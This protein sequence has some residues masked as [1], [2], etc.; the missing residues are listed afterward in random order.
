MKNQDATAE[1]VAHLGGEP[2]TQPA[3]ITLGETV[4]EM[5][6]LDRKQEREAIELYSQIIRVAEQDG[7]KATGSLF[8]R[9][10]A[11]EEKHY[12]AS[13]NLPEG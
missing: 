3:P 9:I 5:L 8:Q 7:D 6:D 10:L 13:A 12:Q 11:D 2:T 1:R 4:A